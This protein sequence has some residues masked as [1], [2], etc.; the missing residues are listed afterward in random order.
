MI[1]EFVGNQQIADMLSKIGVEYGQGFGLHRPE[2]IEK[3]F[4]F[5]SV[6][7]SI[8]KRQ[9]KRFHK[10]VKYYQWRYISQSAL[11]DHCRL[12]G[13]GSLTNIIN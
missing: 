5:K 11:T 7:Q 10:D 4:Q 1:A 2:P 6:L 13:I 12:Q 3:L 8:G 9:L